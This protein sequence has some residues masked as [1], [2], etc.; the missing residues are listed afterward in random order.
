MPLHRHNDIELHYEVAG[1]GPALMLIHGLGSSGA[2]WAF[3][4]PA[5][6][7]HF[8]MIMP[9]LRGS[10]RSHKPKQR[11]AIGEFATDLWS[12]LDAM[13]IDHVSLLGFSLGGAVALEMAVLR[14]RS[15]TRMVLVNSLPDYVIRDRRRWLEAR[16][17]A[18]MVRVLGPRRS[19]RL[20]ARRLFP[21][22]PQAAMR[23][24]VV[25]VVGANSRRAY[26]AT[27]RAL[28]GWSALDRISTLPC[29]TLMLAGE[30]DYTP[31]AE[32]RAYAEKLG[33]E[34]AV[35]RGSRHGT[36]F[37][38]IRATNACA[39]AFLL[40]QPLPPADSLRIDHEDEVPAVAPTLLP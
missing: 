23:E 31:L 3:Q 30:H 13:N 2:D 24:R 10:G 9:D 14:P 26:L 39:L 37:D 15:V 16:L 6:G 4:I 36:P 38:S 32:K 8:Q 12:L 1:Q 11:Y 20:I 7:P 29:P 19:A 5:L 27:I 18:A 17:Q 21:Y 28:V 40:G 34:F 25:D 33:A 22:A 35:V